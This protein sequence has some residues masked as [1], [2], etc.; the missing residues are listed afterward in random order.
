MQI[1]DSLE[2]AQAERW[3]AILVGTSFAAMFFAHALPA[4]WNVLAI[5]KGSIA[6]HADQL[7]YG[8]ARFLEPIRQRNQSGVEKDW[9]AHTLF[10]GN[11]NCWWACTP[12]FHPKDFKLRSTYGVG[13]DWP[14]SYDDLAPYYLQAERLMEI[15]G[16]GSDHILPRKFAFPH[17]PHA[18]SLSDEHL[19]RHSRDWF[20]QP[21]ARATTGRRAPCCANGVCGLCPVDSKFTLVNGLQTVAHPNLKLLTETEARALD[22][23]G[24]QVRGVHVRR[25]SADAVIL[26]DIVGLGANALFNAAILIRSGINSNVLGGYLHEQASQTVIIDIDQKNFFGGT[27][28]TGHG[29]PLYDGPHR[30]ESAAVIIEN[31]NAPVLLRPERDRT[32]NRLSMKLIAED[33]P[34]LQ[35]RVLL[36]EDEPVIEWSG[37]SDYAYRGLARA[38][39]ELPAL[40]PFEIETINFGPYSRTESHIQGTHRMGVTAADS[41]IDDHLALHNHRNVF[42]LGAGAFPTASAANPTLTLSALSLRAGAAVAG[43]S[44]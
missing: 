36:E 23:E 9:V 21:S 35:N 31:Y 13:E 27:S 7:A 43:A 1:L 15:N 41:V 8:Q 26:G 38:R 5:E 39:A 2:Q 10:G 42:A 18:A 37:H 12:R 30:T 33:L 19:R 4:S 44:I 14:I 25:G 34:Q 40:L 6:S 3:D 32:L 29:Y 22:I 28:I 17:P 11:S 16:G 20:S 24:G